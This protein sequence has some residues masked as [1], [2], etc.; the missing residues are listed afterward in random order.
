MSLPYVED[1][2]EYH[3]LRVVET[4]K[5]GIIV[6]K[7]VVAPAFGQSGQGVQFLHAVSLREELKRKRLKEEW[8]WII[9]AKLFS[10]LH[11]LKM[12]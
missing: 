1:T 10:I 5:L 12:K 11:F 3:E 8:L 9:K 4:L 6:K 7:G 2:V